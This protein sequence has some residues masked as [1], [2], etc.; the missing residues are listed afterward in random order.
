MR[1]LVGFSRTRLTLPYDNA[2]VL[3]CNAPYC[4]GELETE[5][6]NRH[7]NGD[8]V[9][10]FGLLK[11]A[12]VARGLYDA[13][14]DHMESM[15]VD[16]RE[17]FCPYCDECMFDIHG[18]DVLVREDGVPIVMETNPYWYSGDS[19]GFDDKLVM[20]RKIITAFGTD[21]D[22]SHC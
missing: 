20:F 7:H 17:R 4:R 22:A 18:L 14:Q 15:R 5:L 9:H 6:T 1:I 12:L 11:D 13:F 16:L 8:N 21:L 10:G 3:V 2:L 19:G